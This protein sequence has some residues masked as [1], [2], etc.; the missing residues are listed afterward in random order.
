MS[1]KLAKSFLIYGIGIGLSQSILIFLVPVYTRYF[2]AKEYGTI[3]ILNTAFTLLTILGLLQ[4]ESAIG[5]FYYEAKDL[6]EKK[7]YISTALWA[8]L[9]LSSLVTIIVFLFSHVFSSILFQTQSFNSAIIIIAL[10][11]PFTTL[12]SLFSVIIRFENKPF[13][14]C[15]ITFLQIASTIGL[16]LWLVII[17]KMGIDGVF[18]GQFYGYVI[19]L[20]LYLYF[21][22]KNIGLIFNKEIITKYL[23]FSLPMLPGVIGGWAVINANRFIMLNLLTVTDIGIYG[24]AYKIASIFRLLELAFRMAW[25][26]F[27]IELYKIPG[28]RKTYIKVFKYVSSI[29]A[30]LVTLS[31]LL[32]KFIVHFITTPAFY[33]SYKLVGWISISFALLII[34]STVTLGPT[35]K[36]KTIYSTYSNFISFIVNFLFLYLLTP[37]YGILGVP[38][39][40][41]LGNIALLI[42]GW[43]FSEKLY[44]VYNIKGSSK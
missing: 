16:S 21:F 27:F 38:Y 14:Y 43:L 35:L 18:Y 34:S 11:I 30:I 2:S 6:Q 19:G 20:V 4:I 23:R 12:F 13:I 5:R 41:I 25:Q 39:S 44:P 31:F 8:V 22:R 10:S 17:K 42:S 28:H 37:K 32:A 40:M 9:G 3:D 33:E 36:F 15:I 26:P 24:V 29:L 1:K 7:Q